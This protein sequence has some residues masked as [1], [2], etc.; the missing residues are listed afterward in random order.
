MLAIDFTETVRRALYAAG[1]QSAWRMRLPEEQRRPA[2]EA[3]GDEVHRVFSAAQAASTLL[4]KYNQ[5]RW[6]NHISWLY[7]LVLK[8]PDDHPTGLY[9]L[10]DANVHAKVEWQ[11]THG[12][13][14][15]GGSFQRL[16]PV[17][18][19]DPRGFV[20]GKVLEL[21]SQLREAGE[22]LRSQRSQY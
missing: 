15:A 7:S 18:L 19:D 3:F 13:E 1:D 6:A 2:V 10:I 12:R 14:Y 4:L 11:L 5:G 16:E 22:S 9:F 8:Q 21:A 20:E 17:F